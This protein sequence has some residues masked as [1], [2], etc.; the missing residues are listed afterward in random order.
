MGL[1]GIRMLSRET[2]A[3]EIVSL[4]DDDAGVLTSVTRLLTSGGYSVRAFREPG[5][6]LDH[7]EANR[8][9]LVILDVWMEHMTGFEVQA[10]LARI[11]PSTRVIIMTG[12]KDPG[13]E[14][15]A[16]EFGA[17]AFFLKPFDGEEFL[18]AV[19]RALLPSTGQECGK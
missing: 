6:F 1:R 8:V 18:A 5:E 11:S 15:T 16:M 17:A 2:P 13:A 3:P 12:R 19:H 14:K 4:V 7:V 10:K 9:P